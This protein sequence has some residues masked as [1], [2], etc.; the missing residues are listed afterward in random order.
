MAGPM[1]ALPALPGHCAMSAFLP[2]ASAERESPA[3]AGVAVMP[4]T[5]VTEIPGCLE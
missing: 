3:D 2:L 1:T 4:E 5:G